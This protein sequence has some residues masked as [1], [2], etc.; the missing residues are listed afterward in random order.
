MTQEVICREHF[1]QMIVTTC[2]FI[3]NLKQKTKS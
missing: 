3:V 2:N 1:G